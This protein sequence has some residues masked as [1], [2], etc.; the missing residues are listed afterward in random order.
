MTRA[1]IRLVVCGA[2]V[3][4]TAAVTV[5]QTSTTS[6]TKKFQV[7]SVD[8]N[9]LVVRLP[10]GTRELTVPDDF[11]F[12]VDGKDAVGARTE[13]WNGRHGDY[14]HEDHRDPCHR[15]RGEE[16]DRGP[17]P[18]PEHHRPHRRREVKQFT[19]S[20]I[21]KRGVKIMR[22]G[23]PAEI[24]D[25]RVNDRLTATIIT[26]K[27]PRVL[28]EKEV[29]ATLAQSGAGAGTPAAAAAT[30]GSSTVTAG[31]SSVPGCGGDVG[32]CAEDTAEDRQPLAGSWACGTRVAPRR[33]GPHPPASSRNA[34]AVR[35][36]TPGLG[37]HG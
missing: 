32:R 12:N 19:Q 28:T 35:Q 29:S 11:R 22:E 1:M 9:Q 24:S 7:I 2:L 34:L 4:L 27:P 23:K 17:L 20:D 30:P 13:A 37:R 3:C 36:S 25:F 14:H 8:G 5:A 26:S 6:E 21:D 10:E 33:I 18:W 15:D 16:R 31:T